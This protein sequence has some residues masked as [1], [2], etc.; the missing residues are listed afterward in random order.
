MRAIDRSP[1]LRHR[2]ADE[3]MDDLGITDRAGE[4]LGGK[5]VARD[6][7]LAD[8]EKMLRTD[9]P[10]A[11][12]LVYVSGPPGVG[13]SALLEIFS[14]RVLGYGGGRRGRSDPSR[15]GVEALY[16]R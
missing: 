10:G 7:E 16:R 6:Q 5:I 1:A 3:L 4:I 15:V 11:P 9:S 12:T 8:L 13:K 2:Y 14:Q